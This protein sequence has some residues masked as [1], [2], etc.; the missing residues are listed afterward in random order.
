MFVEV[1][2][3]FVCR[4]PL[5]ALYLHL[6]AHTQRL[7]IL[8]VELLWLQACYVSTAAMLAMYLEALYWLL[9]M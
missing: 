1:L 3:M 4:G 9:C 5:L 8:Y 6:Q 2:C 7:Y